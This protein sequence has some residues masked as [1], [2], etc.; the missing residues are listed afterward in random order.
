MKRFLFSL[1]CILGAYNL[2]MSQTTVTGTVTDVEGDALIGANILVV[3]TSVGTITDFDGNYEIEVPDGANVLQFSYTGFETQEVTIDGRTVI[4]LELA[5]GQLLEEVVVTALGIERSKKS[6]GYATQEIEPA[7]VLKVKDINFMNSLSGKV[8]GMDIKRSNTLGGAT[9]VIIRGY[10]SLT[11][12]NQALF[13]VDGTPINNAIGAST[14]QATGRGGYNYGNTAMDINPED[15]ESINVLKGAA[16]TALYGSRAANGIVLIT[17]KKGARNKGIGIEVTSGVTFGQIDK[18]TMP[19]YQDE[20]G[21]GYSEYLGWYADGAFDFADFGDGPKH[22]VVTYE[23]ASFG[24]KFDPSKQVYTWKSYFP[25]LPEYGKTQPWVAG[26]NTPVDFYETSRALNNS[27]SF[28]GGN[29]E[30]TFRLGYTNYDTKGN[31][32]NSEIKRHNISFGGSYDLAERLTASTT[33]NYIRTNGLGRYGTGYDNRN[34]NQAQR[35]WWQTNVDIKEQERVYKETGKNISY[36][37]YGVL[38]LSQPT[39]PH[40][41]DNP[42]YNRYENFNTD[43]RNRLM[44]NGQLKYEVTDWMNL[45]GRVA[46]DRYDELREERIAIESVDVPSYLR[47]N[48]EFQETNYDLFADFS[49]YFGASDNLSMDGL[50]GVNI[51]RAQYSSITAQTNGGLVVPGLYALSN[52]VNAPNAPGESQY[53]LG[54][55][56][57]YARL[58]FGLNQFLYLD[59]AGRYDVSSTLPKDNNAYFYPSASMSI[60]FSELINSN[61]ISFGQLRFNVA[62]VGSDAPVQAIKNTYVLGNPFGGTTLASVSNTL[63]NAN[64][65]PERTRSIEA[66]LAM[67]FFDRLF[68]FDV[69]VYKSNSFDQIL[70]VEVTAATGVSFQ[71]KNAG[72]IENKG[73]EATLNINPVATA[74]FEWSMGLNFSKNV[75]EV[76]S[77]FG[78]AQNL[79]LG[80]VQGGITINAA[81]GE[82]YGAIKGTNYAYH[83]D[84]RK[85]VNPHPYGG[86]RYAK[87][88]TTEVIGYMTPDWRAGLNNNLRFK[89]LSLSFLIDMQQGGDFFSLDT[90]YGFATGLYDVTAGTNRDGEPV[91]LPVAEGGGIYEDGAVVQTG[92]NEQGYPISAGEAN[93]ERFYASDVYTSFGYA[94]APNAMHVYDA[95]FLKLREVNLTYTLPNRIVAN[96]PF[97]GMSISLI[98]R[99]LWIIHKN[100]PY[101]DPE[102]TL[103]AGSIQGYQSGAYPAVKEYGATINLKF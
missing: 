55:N 88:P 7:E 14:N 75:N 71:Y 34:P 12:N 69:T 76:K 30:G 56:G 43:N 77:L 40:Y 98:G 94:I 73:I 8:A 62:Q 27:I 65:L 16:A 44:G 72:E 59:L 74:D 49:N 90:W 70:P 36:N 81:V 91:R 51:R 93:T 60:V 41:A 92:V 21:A 46:T 97:Q 61:A 100:A 66:G 11:G 4:N 42:Y 78:D 58:N 5:A 32:P 45:T 48:I 22:T 101:T 1:V 17:T 19:T 33:F 26:E 50:L 3:G 20:Y 38:D 99:N 15:I 53:E 29:E 96:S 102:A 64:L 52:S 80:S 31:L 57:Y 86:V 82:P 6:L 25:E 87:S 2:I 54:T 89:N 47:R 95:S 67:D 10:K 83:T 39:R 13:V 9:N 84:G 35:Q 85:I 63:N 28:S 37:N 18:T 24:A 79:L 68:G 23:D 103:N